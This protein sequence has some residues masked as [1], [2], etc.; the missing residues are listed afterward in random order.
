M[1]GYWHTIATPDGQ[2]E[3]ALSARLAGHCLVVER[4]RGEFYWHWTVLNCLGHE[5]EGGLAPDAHRAEQLAE[6]AAFHIH[7]PT[8]GDWVAGLIR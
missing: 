3:I 6:E 5:I 1:I 4:W 2:A 7:P 8:T